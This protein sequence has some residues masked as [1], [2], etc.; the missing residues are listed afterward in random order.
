MNSKFTFL[1][2]LIININFTLAQTPLQV[3]KI[4][5]DYDIELIKSQALNLDYTNDS[6]KNLTHQKAVLLNIPI[7]FYDINGNY[8]ELQGFYDNGNPKYFVTN[9]K[10]AAKSTR[11]NFL[12]NNG[13]MGLNIEGQNMTAYV[14][15]GGHAL[16]THVEFQTNSSSRIILGDATVAYPVDHATHVSGTIIAKGVANQAKGMAPQAQ[17][18]SYEWNNDVTEATNAVLEGMLVSNHSYGEYFNLID[19]WRIGAYTIDARRWDNLMKNAPYFLMV[20]AAGNDG[21]DDLNNEYPLHG[22]SNFDKLTGE[23]IAKNNLVVAN[24]LD[25]NVNTITGNPTSTPTLNSSSSQGPTDDLRIKP[26]ITA[27]GTTVYSSIS[28][29]NNAYDTYD[30][31]SMSSPNAAGIVLLLQQLHNEL[32]STFMRSSTVR[33]LLMHTADDGGITGPDAG[34]GWGYINTKKAAEIIINDGNTSEVEE[35]ILNNAETKNFQVVSDGVNPLKVSICWIDPPA[36]N[37]NTGI[38]NREDPVLVNDLDLRITKNATTFY[39]WKLTDVNSNS[40]GDNNVDNFERIDINSASGT[41]EVSIS[42]KGT[43]AASQNFSLVISGVSSTSLSMDD[44]LTNTFKIFPNP[45]KGL[46]TIQSNEYIDSLIITNIIGEV[47]YQKDYF[48]SNINDLIDVSFLKCGIYLAKI[49]KNNI[50][51]VE[52]FILE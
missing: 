24:G 40:T 44:N 46:I 38:A 30:G 4:T 14:W 41:Y 17:I 52:K 9:N 42:H 43:L 5:Q 18:K 21:L 37:V 29:A 31:T 15:D 32:K 45:N 8:A 49:K 35:I 33:G 20:V 19:D 2:I 47:L 16:P 48:Q 27:N 25:L 3:V 36:N 28:T 22:F 6:I 51:V 23:R 11:A 39:P 10:T 1:S 7:F 12:H 34:F 26:D 50:F 13:G